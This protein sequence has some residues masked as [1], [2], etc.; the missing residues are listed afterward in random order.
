MKEKTVLCALIFI[1]YASCALKYNNEND[2]HVLPLDGGKSAEIINYVGTKQIVVIPPVIQGMSVTRIGDDSFRQKEILAVIIPGSVTAIGSRAFAYNPLAG[3]EI[4]A[5][6]TEIG[7]SAFAYCKFY[8]GITIPSSVKSIDRYAF[9]YCR[10]V[11]SITIPASVTVF[12]DMAFNGW[13]VLQTI[14]IMGFESQAAADNVWRASW[15]NGCNAKIK[16]Q[17]TIEAYPVL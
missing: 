6:V 9:A 10:D 2:F 4:P 8:T 17:G 13:N 5:G 1:V 7:E 14:D 11:P 16:Y 15:R 3:I 12:G